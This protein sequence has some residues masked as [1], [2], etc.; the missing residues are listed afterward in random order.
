MTSIDAIYELGISHNKF[1]LPLPDGTSYPDYLFSSDKRPLEFLQGFDRV[2]DRDW[3]DCTFYDLGCSEGSTT[4]GMSQMGSTVYG[5]EGRTDGVER[6]KVLKQI[7]GFERTHFSVGNVDHEE[8]YRQVDAIFNAGVLYHLEDP[9]TCLERCAE[10]AR[11][12]IYLDTG[13][14]PRSHEE[15]EG[16]KFASKFGRVHTIRRHGLE[17]E[18]VDFA[19]PSTTAEKKGGVRR[20]PRAGIGNTNSVWLSHASTVELMKVLGFPYHETIADKPHIPRLRTCFWR[21]EPRA[22]SP[23]GA[24]FKP[25]PAE[26]PRE[27]AIAATRAR[28]LAYLKRTGA[29]VVVV[30]HEPLLAAVAEDL[31]EGGARVDAVIAA[32]GSLGDTLTLQGLNKLLDGRS[33]LVALATHDVARAS[34]NLMKLDRFGY[35]FTSFALEHELARA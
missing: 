19:E 13:H 25:L 34:F 1:T 6:A 7:I 20:G 26:A 3:S 29:P 18:A 14:A 30:G 5:V 2:R 10:N 4:F 35:V 23:L 33:G 11:L 15:R 22:P 31:R 21:T 8:S 24:L 12:F 32:P 27:A 16:S 28:D 9:V 17:L